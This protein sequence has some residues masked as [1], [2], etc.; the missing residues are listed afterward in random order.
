MA[1]A[2]GSFR[3]VFTYAYSLSTLRFL[4]M[5]SSTVLS[6]ATIISLRYGNLCVQNLYHVKIVRTSVV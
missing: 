3:N 5:Y 2:S 1:K 6:I 4:R